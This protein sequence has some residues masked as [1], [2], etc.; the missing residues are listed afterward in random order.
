MKTLH[1]SEITQDNF[2]LLRFEDQFELRTKFEKL[3]EEESEKERLDPNNYLNA[4]NEWIY[5]CVYSWN[6]GMADEIIN[7]KRA[8]QSQLDKAK[9]FKLRMQKVTEGLRKNRDRLKNKLKELEKEKEM[10]KESNS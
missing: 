7:E 1:L 5:R 10:Q 4:Y 3:L 9:E 6:L 2:H 8:L